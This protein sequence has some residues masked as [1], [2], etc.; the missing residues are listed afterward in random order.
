MKRRV[1]ATLMEETS[2]ALGTETDSR[3]PASSEQRCSTKQVIQ[4]LQGT[5]WRE[6]R[7]VPRSLKRVVR[8]VVR[9]IDFSLPLAQD[10]EELGY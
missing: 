10:M 7:L 3:K 5:C 8:L 1:V 4:C 2:Y 9:F 6:V